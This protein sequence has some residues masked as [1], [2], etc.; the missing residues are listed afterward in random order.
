[1]LP[2]YSPWKVAEQFMLLEALYPGRIDLGLGRAPGGDQRTARAVAGGVPH[3][4]DFPEQVQALLWLLSGQIPETHPYADLYLQPRGTTK[5]EL[6]MLGSSDFGGRL[7]AKLGINFCFAHFISP[8]FGES[9]MQ[10]YRDQFIA[11]YQQQSYSAVA[12]FVVCADTEAEA[13][14]L[15]A[16]VDLR[17]LY[18]ARGINRPIPSIASARMTQ[19]SSHEI[20]IIDH[21]RARNIVGTPDQVVERMLRIQSDFAADEIVVLTVAG[22]YKA[23]L[24]ST[25]LLAEAFKS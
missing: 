24:R 5:P 11:G 3:S 10:S 19:Y 4:D 7:A 1:M 8:D 16:A 6:W 14:D 13:A 25:Q 18:Q 21:E 17:R 9:V 12:L 23:R 20:A 15:S 2:Y 22:S